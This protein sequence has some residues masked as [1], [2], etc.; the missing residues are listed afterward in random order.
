M[1]K[2]HLKNAKEIDPNYCDTQ[3]VVVFVVV[4]VVFV[5]VVVVVVLWLV[6]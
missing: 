2:F 3:V 6:F 5:F 1:A 4:V